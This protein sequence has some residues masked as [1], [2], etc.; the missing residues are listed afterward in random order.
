ML[1]PL[2]SDRLSTA[3]LKRRLD[4]V[5]R[6]PGR[7]EEL[8]KHCSAVAAAVRWQQAGGALHTWAAISRLAVSDCVARHHRRN[9]FYRP[10]PH[11]AQ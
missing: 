2:R 7:R 4:S 8:G 6:G 9:P 10:D 5:E 11:P 1:R 3:P